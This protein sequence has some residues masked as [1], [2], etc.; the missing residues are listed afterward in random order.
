MLKIN[1]YDY[2]GLIRSYLT[3]DRPSAKTAQ[4]RMSYSGVYLYSYNSVLAKLDTE[5][6]ILYIDSDI[7]HY[8]NTSIKHAN[9][10]RAKAKDNFTRFE[11]P[12]DASTEDTVTYYT[13]IIN[14][15]ITKHTRA[16]VE[17]SKHYWKSQI[18]NTLDELTIYLDLHTIKN[19]KLR[20]VTQPIFQQLF[21][22]KLLKG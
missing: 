3:Q 12:I 22:L 4:N 5:R 10:L 2:E 9:N 8:S 11:V 14:H 16:R 15:A 21:E 1:S 19:S 13:N 7:V 20:K 17:H 18:F 6:K